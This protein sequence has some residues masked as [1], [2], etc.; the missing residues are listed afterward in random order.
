MTNAKN[1]DVICVFDR[2]LGRS[3]EL[4]ALVDLIRS[5]APT[6]SSD[7]RIW[8]GPDDQRELQNAS[9]DDAEAAIR[10][11][12]LERGATFRQLVEQ[13]GAGAERAFGTVELRGSTSSLVVVVSMDAWPFVEQ[14]SGR[15]KLGNRVS[16]Q[17]RKSRIE[18]HEAQEWAAGAFGAVCARTSP[19]WGAC[20]LSDEYSAKVMSVGSRVEAVGWDLA[21][22]LPGVFWL[23]FFGKRYVDLIGADRLVDASAMEIKALDH[24]VLLQVHDRADAWNTI[25]YQER[26]RLVLEAL[27]TDLFFDRSRPKPHTRAP[28]WSDIERKAD[29]RDEM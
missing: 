28:D 8:R 17:V 14:R 11:A 18:R 26:E 6:W 4:A 7:L 21:R 24:G 23:N 3:G 10:A 16:I 29:Q 20:C 13:F 19:V 27:G 12:A 22:F 25:E 9:S 5:V 1:V 2:D 15:G